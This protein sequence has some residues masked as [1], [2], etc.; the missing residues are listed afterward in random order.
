MFSSGRNFF[1]SRR[2]FLAVTAGACIAPVIAL[3]QDRQVLA[4]TVRD[5]SLQ[6]DQHAPGNVFIALRLNW[7]STEEF[8]AYTQTRIG[9][10]IALS[11]D[12][13]IVLRARLVEAIHAG[14]IRI[15]L[16]SDEDRAQKILR[17]LKDK[18][19]KVEV[20]VLD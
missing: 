16:N 13:E 9:K 19:A 5:A 1:S 18:S 2:N 7:K 10:T 15:S 6:R 12:G 8:G 20:H 4:L 3:A 11:I 17:R 14:N